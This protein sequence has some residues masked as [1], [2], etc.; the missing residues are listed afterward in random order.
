MGLK[1]VQK[2]SGKAGDVP[3]EVPESRKGAGV[4]AQGFAEGGVGELPEEA[5]QEV[6]IEEA[7]QP[8]EQVAVLGEW[9]VAAEEF[10]ATIPGYHLFPNDY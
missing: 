6:E 3:G 7:P 4:A 8:A 5:A 2:S 10:P 1:A 9:M